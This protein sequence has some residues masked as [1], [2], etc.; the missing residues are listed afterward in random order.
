MTSFAD[1]IGEG[2]FHDENVKELLSFSC[3]CLTLLLFYCSAVDEQ[4]AQTQEQE[5]FLLGLT[6]AEEGKDLKNENKIPLQSSN[7]GNYGFPK[8]RSYRKGKVLCSL[9]V[10]RAMSLY[11]SC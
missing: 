2:Y 4:N 6:T 5:S 3:L 9:G 1:E 10:L 11:M 7:T 8:G